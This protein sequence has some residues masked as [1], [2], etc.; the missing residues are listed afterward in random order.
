[1]TGLRASNFKFQTIPA[2]DRHGQDVAV[3]DILPNIVTR[4]EQYMNGDVAWRGPREKSVSFMQTLI[5][6]STQPGD[7]VL[8]CT[9]STGLKLSCIFS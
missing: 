7:V 3:D 2:L 5:L 4:E 1:M 6:A 8:D 9:A